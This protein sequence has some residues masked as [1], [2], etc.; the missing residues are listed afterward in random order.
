VSAPVNVIDLSNTPLN[1]VI[2][3]AGGGSLSLAL[4]G[5][6]EVAAGGDNTW[7]ELGP[8]TFGKKL[9]RAKCVNSLTGIR[10][11]AAGNLDS[12]ALQS[13]GTALGWGLNDIGQL[14]NGSTTSSSVPIAVSDLNGVQAIAAGIDTSLALTQ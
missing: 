2:A 12:F 3:A 5:N 13:D 8:G 11:I 6:G 1:G 14:G 9:L 10:A 7:G 4:R